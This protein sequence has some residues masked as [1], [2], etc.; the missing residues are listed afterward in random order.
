MGGMT[1]SIWLNLDTD[2]IEK[3]Q[4]A[5]I[6]SSGGQSKKSRGFAFLY[7]HGSYVFIISTKDKQWK[8]IIDTVPTK[9][10]INVAFVWDKHEQL[11]YYL[12]G[13]KQ[14]SVSGKKTSR[15][16]DK[17]GILTISR[18]NNALSEQFMFPLK[19]MSLALWDKP[20]LPKQIKSIYK[21]S[22]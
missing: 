10:W 8:L 18:P 19:I 13:E 12:N 21:S 22:K 15:P 7:F 11:T 16:D 6:I 4:D 1:V 2:D 9:Q 14:K 17:Y 20:L 3:D 5:Y